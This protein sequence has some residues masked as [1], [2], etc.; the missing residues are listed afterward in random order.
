[1]KIKVSQVKRSMLHSGIWNC[2]G[3]NVQTAKLVS[4]CS[5]VDG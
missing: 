5:V 1:M 2:E 3:W 4:K